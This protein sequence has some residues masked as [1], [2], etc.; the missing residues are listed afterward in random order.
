MAQST[1][2]VAADAST[3]RGPSAVDLAD[4]CVALDVG[5]ARRA[6]HFV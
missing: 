5:A 1:R 3:T 2:T 4:G 6:F